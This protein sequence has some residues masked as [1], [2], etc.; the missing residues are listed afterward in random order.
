[1]RLMSWVVV[2]WV[3]YLVGGGVVV[4]GGREGRGLVVEGVL[5]R[6]RVVVEFLARIKH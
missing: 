5:G 4:L 3:D 1:M 2:G 6:R